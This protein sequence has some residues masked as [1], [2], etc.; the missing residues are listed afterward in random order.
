MNNFFQSLSRG[1]LAALSIGLAI[2]VILYMDP[3]HSLCNSEKEQFMSAQEN[4]LNPD[5]SLK[6]AFK[7]KAKSTQERLYFRC[8]DSQSSGGCLE[9]FLKLKPFMSD[10]EV[11]SGQCRKSMYRQ[12]KVKQV[13]TQS[14]T[15]MALLA[16]G[17]EPP[18]SPQQKY[19]WLDQADIALFCKLKKL[20]R[21]SLS[22]SSWNQQQEKILQQLPGASSLSRQQLWKRSLLSTSCKYYN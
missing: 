17:S 20:S 7:K 3:P 4:F 10:F 6:K 12:K 18:S 11:V 1:T 5:P 9:F 2:V 16:W 13:F 14:L 15:L 22:E 21:M 8:K 19:S